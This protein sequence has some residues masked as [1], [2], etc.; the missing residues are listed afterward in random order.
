M[1][2]TSSGFGRRLPFTMLFA[3]LCELT[4]GSPAPYA[5]WNINGFRVDVL[6]VEKE[7]ERLCVEARSRG[8]RVLMGRI[9]LGLGALTVVFVLAGFSVLGAAAGRINFTTPRVM[10]Y[11]PGGDDWEPAVASDGQGHVLPYDSSERSLG[12]PC[13]FGGH[14]GHSGVPR[15][16]PDVHGPVSAHDQFRGAV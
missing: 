13:L 16:R 9:A 10:G 1:S 6:R 2:T 4:M 11:P 15:R 12:L 5:R 14:D 7:S 8:T 3:R